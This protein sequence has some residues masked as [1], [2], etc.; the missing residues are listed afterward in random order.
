MINLQ[1]RERY[2]FLM[3]I[4]SEHVGDICPSGTN[5]WATYLLTATGNVQTPRFSTSDDIFDAIDDL[6]NF[7]LSKENK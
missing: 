2:G 4:D 6:E 3:H 5:E 1:L 7:H